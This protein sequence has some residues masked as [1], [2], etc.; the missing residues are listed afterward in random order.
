VRRRLPAAPQGSAVN[1]V[2]INPVETDKV[3]IVVEHAR[4]AATAVT[5]LEIR[6][7]GP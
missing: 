4:P 7:D 2:W 3:R 6:G 1:T 5:E